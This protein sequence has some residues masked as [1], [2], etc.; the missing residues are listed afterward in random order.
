MSV[1]VRLMIWSAGRFVVNKL[2]IGNSRR[3][4]LKLWIKTKI[5][6]IKWKVWVVGRYII[7]R[8]P[9]QAHRRA[10]LKSLIK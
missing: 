2:P 10:R 5:E 8:L 4:L 3:E 6:V 7:N 9:M 1:N